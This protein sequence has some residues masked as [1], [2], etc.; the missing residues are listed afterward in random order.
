MTSDSPIYLSLVV[1]VYNEESNIPELARRLIGAARAVGKPTEIVFVDDGSADGSLEAMRGL[2]SDMADIVV[3]ELARN[4][5]QH[6]AVLAEPAP[7]SLFLNFGDSALDFELRAFVGSVADRLT[8]I[9]DLNGRITA[10]F[11][12]AGIEIAFPQLDLH[13]RDLPPAPGPAPDAA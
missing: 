2:S 4:F 7:R 12:E 8:T 5:G 9:N 11:A 1:P 10:L 3:V 6:P 13:V